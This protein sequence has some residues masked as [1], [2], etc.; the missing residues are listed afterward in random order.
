MT[1]FLTEDKDFREGAVICIDKPLEWTSF[2]VVKKIKYSLQKQFNYKLKVGHA[3]T[4]DPLATGLVIICTGK[5]TKR[6]EEY[7][8]QIKEYLCTVKLGATTPSFDLETQEDNIFPFEHITRELID[9]KLRDFIGEIDQIP[10]IFSALRVNG[11][12]AYKK[13]RKGED[14]EIKSRKINIYEIDVIGFESPYLELRI[15]CGKGTYVRSIA[16]DIGKS[17]G[18]GAYL[19]ALRRTAIGNY[20][21][22]NAVGINDFIG[23]LDEN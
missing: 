2:D 4:L 19:T 10:P 15:V 20:K 11:E 1:E 16:R 14:F 9:D 6:I 5:G 12:R 18:S 7:M 22:E 3:G 17:L 23:K 21:V 8:G 13:A